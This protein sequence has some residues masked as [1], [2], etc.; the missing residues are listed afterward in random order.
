MPRPSKSAHHGAGF[1]KKG[2]MKQPSVKKATKR[3]KKRDS[4]YFGK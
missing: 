2:L 4:K 1:T 3:A